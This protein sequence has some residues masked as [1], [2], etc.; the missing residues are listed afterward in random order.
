MR[1][2]LLAAIG[3]TTFLACS[4]ST[5]PAAPPPPP[6]PPPALLATGDW[7]GDWRLLTD[8]STGES[9]LVRF[10]TIVTDVGGVLSGSCKF[11]ALE[12]L[13]A[14]LACDRT[15]GTRAGD[16][17]SASVNLTFDFAASTGSVFT[18]SG[19]LQPGVMT[20]SLA[21]YSGYEF[22]PRS[23]TRNQVTPEEASDEAAEGSDARE[24]L[25]RLLRAVPGRSPLR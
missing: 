16:H 8:S 7:V 22:R 24:R 21:I 4:D 6:P 19:T 3:L 5:G 10:N 25:V 12:L 20:G 9:N 14:F 1:T 15:A 11:E 13:P 2:R 18:F 23:A 17:V